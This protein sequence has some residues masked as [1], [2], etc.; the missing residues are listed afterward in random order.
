MKKSIEERVE[1]LEEKLNLRPNWTV[2]IT[3]IYRYNGVDHKP[4]NPI[5]EKTVTII[6]MNPGAI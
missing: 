6:K 5:E 2:T 4:D 3:S 1:V